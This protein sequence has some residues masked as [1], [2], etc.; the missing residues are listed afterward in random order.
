MEEKDKRVTNR[1]NEILRSEEHNKAKV[2]ISKY[3]WIYSIDHIW[4]TF[5][6]TKAPLKILQA[7]EPVHPLLQCIKSVFGLN[8]KEKE[9]IEFNKQKM[10]VKKAVEPDQ[11]VWENLK[12][13]YQ[14]QTFRSRI[15][16]FLSI[17]TI[18][19]V[20]IITS[21]TDAADSLLSRDACPE[22]PSFD[23]IY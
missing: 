22:E 14:E 5:K 10:D 6:S 17:F 3:D 19:S 12:F 23:E 4:V 20:I 21:I 11:I 1:W 16:F 7:Y 15:V 9:L 8:A 13:S 18:F 2:N